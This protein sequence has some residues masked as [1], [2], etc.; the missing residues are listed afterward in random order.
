[1][2]DLRN[3][4]GDRYAIFMGVDDLSFEGLAVGADGLLAGLV[5]AFPKET[6]ALYKLVKAGRLAEALKLYQWFMPLLH[7]DVSTKLVQNLKLVEALVGVGNE[8][9]RR[10]R[11][12]LRG[13]D[14][15]FVVQVVQQ[16]LATRPD[17]SAYL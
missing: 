10:P 7:L 9:V 12:P 16:A 3:A 6:V 17:V 2:T 1:V 5:V 8:N 4:V 11:Q 15:E 13:A 14:R